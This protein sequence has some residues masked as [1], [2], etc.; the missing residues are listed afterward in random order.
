LPIQISI[1][2]PIKIAIAKLK[3]SREAQFLELKNAEK[4]DLKKAFNSFDF[5]FDS[6]DYWKSNY[7]LDYLKWRYDLVPIIPYYAHFNEKACVIFRLKSGGLGVELRICDVFGQKQEIEQLLDEV[8]YQNDF[9]YMSISGFESVK[10][11]GILKQ[12]KNFG[13]DVTIRTL[14]EKNLDDFRGLKNW[15]PALGDLE[16]F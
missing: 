7:S 2:K 1:K 12:N 10:L 14:A 8:Y 5:K 15:H 3:G 9:D 13:P 4:Y 16:V 6:G 11:P